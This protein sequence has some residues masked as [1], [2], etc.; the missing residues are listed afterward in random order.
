[1]GEMINV[2]KILV[3]KPEEMKPLGRPRHSWEENIKMGHR[4]I[5]LE[6]VD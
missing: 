4:E 5:G 1:M 2:Y 3:V 6:G